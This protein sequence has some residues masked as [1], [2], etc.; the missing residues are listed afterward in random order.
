MLHLQKVRKIAHNSSE[1]NQ[2]NRD[3]HP[4]IDGVGKWCLKIRIYIYRGD[5]KRRE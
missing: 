2:E 4:D 5:F 1:K 3:G